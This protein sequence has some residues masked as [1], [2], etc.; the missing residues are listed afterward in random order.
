MNKPWKVDDTPVVVT[1]TLSRAK[2]IL[3]LEKHNFIPYND[4]GIDA[5]NF[6][7]DLERGISTVERTISDPGKEA[8][9]ELHLSTDS[10]TS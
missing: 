4:K 6:L 8:T 5:L 2:A 3:D 7:N 1:T 10:K 9:G